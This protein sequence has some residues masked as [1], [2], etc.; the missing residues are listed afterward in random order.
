MAGPARGP[1]SAHRARP[2][3]QRRQ[4][5]RVPM[6][7]HDIKAASSPPQGPGR[8]ETARSV[9]RAGLQGEGATPFEPRA[10]LH[11]SWGQDALLPDR[12]RERPVLARRG[13]QQPDVPSPDLALP[14]PVAQ[15]LASAE[16]LAG[17]I[18][19]YSERSDQPGTHTHTRAGLARR[20]AS[21][22]SRS[23]RHRVTRGPGRPYR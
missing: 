14:D 16:R 4:E 6:D 10:Q 20:A 5:R 22:D 17:P 9:R 21:S 18:A 19:S 23:P 3:R 7:R 13:R 15:G 2:A 8:R 1:Q 11:A 12:R